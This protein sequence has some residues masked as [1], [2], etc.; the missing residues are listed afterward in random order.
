MNNFSPG[1]QFKHKLPPLD[2]NKAPAFLPGLTFLLNRTRSQPR[3]I[4][5]GLDSMAG[6][7]SEKGVC[8]P[9]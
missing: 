3:D 6:D 1:L 2:K 5:S 8:S 4:Q 9:S 7:E